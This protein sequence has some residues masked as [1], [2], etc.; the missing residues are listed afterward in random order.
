[1]ARVDEPLERGRPTEELIGVGE[2]P[3]SDAND[4]ALLEQFVSHGEVDMTFTGA[5]GVRRAA[6]RHRDSILEMP[7]S[8]RRLQRGEPVIR[9]RFIDEN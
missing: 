4:R 9:T 1:M 7:G 2:L 5:A 3:A 6:Q 8:S